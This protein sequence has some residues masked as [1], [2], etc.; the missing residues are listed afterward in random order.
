MLTIG[1]TGGIG[2]GK[3]TVANVLTELGAL[4][5]DADQIG[6]AVYAPG[7]PAR[8]ELVAAFGS[9]IVGPDDKI[10]RKALGRIVFADTA[11]LK[12]LNAIVHPRIFERMGA[13]VR[14]ARAA[15]ER[16]LIVIEAAILIEA[17][18]QNSVD[19]VWLVVTTHEHVIER[20]ERDR[21]MTREQIEARIRAQLPEPER[22]KWADVVIANDGTLDE[23]RSAT[24]VIFEE[25]RIRAAKQSC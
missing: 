7:T 3:S 6:H 16:R 2:S 10:D 4:V 14:E 8:D 17:G 18:W 5:W 25:A 12:R 13:M 19:E 15:G 21:Q 22:R 11:A 20:V 9:A 24:T 1:L 23:L